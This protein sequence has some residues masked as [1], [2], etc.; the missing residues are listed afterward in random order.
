MCKKVSQH[1]ND[2]FIRVPIHHCIRMFML[3]GGGGGGGSV[4]RSKG[5]TN[6]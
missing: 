1:S 3:G 4:N 6:F 2:T 5:Q